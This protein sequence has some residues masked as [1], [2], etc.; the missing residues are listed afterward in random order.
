MTTKENKFALEYLIDGNASRAYIAAGYSP[1]NPDKNAYKLLS[2]PEIAEFIKVEQDKTSKKLEIT[3][4]KILSGAQK[5]IEVYDT[6]IELSLKEKLTE[7]EQGQFARLM[8]ILRASDSNK[9]REIL[10]K[11]NGWEN[12]DNIQDDKTIESININIVRKS[13]EQQD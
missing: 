6:L 7:I 12:K 1:K 8:M 5:M 9:A 11:A 2:R 3:R 10:L 13:D 4:E